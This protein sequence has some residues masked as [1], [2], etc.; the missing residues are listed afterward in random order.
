MR[1]KASKALAI[2]VAASLVIAGCSKG[3]DENK[4]SSTTTPSGTATESASASATPAEP[5]VISVAPVGGGIAVKSTGIQTDDVSKEIEKRIGVQI[6]INRLPQSDGKTQ[7]ATMLASN[8]LDDLINF[9]NGVEAQKNIEAAVKAGLIIPLDD[10]LKA[11]PP[12]TTYDKTF[13]ERMDFNR[14]HYSPDGK[15]YTISQAGGPAP[16]ILP[17]EGFNIRWDLYK[18]LGYPE[19]TN[20]DELLNLLA[21]MWKLEPKT[22]DGKK[23]YPLGAWFSEGAGWGDVTVHT[24]NQMFKGYAPLNNNPIS[25]YDLGTR[26]LYAN[27]PITDTNSPYYDGVKFLYKAQKMGMLDPESLTQKYDKW[28]EKLY[29]GQY[30]MF[31]TG[32]NLPGTKNSFTNAGTPEKGFVSL[33]PYP[34]NNGMVMDWVALTG[35]G[36]WAISKNCKNPEKALAL[37]QFA[38]S[39]DG[40]RLLLGGVEGKTWTKDA[41]GKLQLTPEFLK[42]NAEKETSMAAYDQTGVQK[43]RNMAGYGFNGISPKDNAH[44]DLTK[45]PD[46][47]A[48]NYSEMEKDA[49]AHY[50]ITS[51][52]LVDIYTSRAKTVLY[53]LDYSNVF[54]PMPDDIKT[55]DGNLISYVYKNEFDMI[56][57]K[58]DAEFEKAQKKFIDGAAKYDSD[59][60][61]NWYKEQFAK[62]KFEIDPFYEVALKDYPLK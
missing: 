47:L 25:Y 45:E 36:G 54:D 13:Y 43:Y 35:G 60:V 17:S 49:I 34:N 29:N 20:D 44:M 7:L 55:A 57:A 1:K 2:L 16:D 41:N 48:Q 42:L 9:G 28:Q 12:D 8:D 24:L 23:V 58:N 3:D 4:S 40:A 59:K 30:L 22:K 21:E 19:I 32:W 26:N 18:K 38:S 10:L 61:Y 11:N 56:Y 50:G 33:P 31:G 6:K 27:N 5:V 62:A 52:H 37:L 14:K 15:L 53:L 46:Y 39:P 51:N